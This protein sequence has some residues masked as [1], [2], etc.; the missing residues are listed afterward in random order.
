MTMCCLW[1]ILLS[2]T[3][4]AGGGQEE[5]RC[6]TNLKFSTFLQALQSLHN[7]TNLKLLLTLHTGYLSK[8]MLQSDKVTDMWITNDQDQRKTLKCQNFAKAS[9]NVGWIW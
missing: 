2:S 6:F 8:T 9:F 4:V 7:F 1:G 5:S 3:A